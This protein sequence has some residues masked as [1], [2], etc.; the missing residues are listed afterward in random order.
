MNVKALKKENKSLG[1]KLETKCLEYK[2]LKGE[3]EN[4]KKERNYLLLA[5]KAST[6]EMK[7]K[8]KEFEKKFVELNDFKKIKVEEER[9]QKFAKIK[10]IKTKSKNK[11]GKARKFLKRSRTIE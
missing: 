3:L 10:E 4:T 2:H 5:L 11:N 7:V 9:Q 8:N 6:E 1:E